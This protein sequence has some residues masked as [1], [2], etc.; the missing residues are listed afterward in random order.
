[1]GASAALYTLAIRLMA[2]RNRI[3]SKI[4]LFR[5]S[6]CTPSQA[7][8]ST[9]TRS[10]GPLP[11]G[12]RIRKRTLPTAAPQ[13]TRSMAMTASSPAS[14]STAEASAGASRVVRELERDRSPPTRWTCSLG[15]SRVT[16]SSVAGCWMVFMSPLSAL[17]P[18]RC[19][20]S[21]RPVFSRASAA[22]VESAAKRS[23]KTRVFRLSHRSARLP[24]KTLSST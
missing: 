24:A 7:E 8:R 6:H 16:A 5:R 18:Y 1:M 20:I 2:A 3:I 15:V 13:V 12:K 4:P 11:S 10:L 14:A 21:S 17:M 23:Q 19:Q 9:G 22:A